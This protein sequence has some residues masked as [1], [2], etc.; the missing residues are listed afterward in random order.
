MRGFTLVELLVT[1]TLLALLLG[2]GFHWQK[3]ALP[4]HRV[5]SASNQV[6]G[7]IQY[8]RAEALTRGPIYL[9][10]GNSHCDRFQV[11]SSLLLAQARD[12]VAA[13]T[14]DDVFH[15]LDLPEG[16]TLTWR[17][18]RGSALRYER[19]GNLYYQNGSF[20][21]CNQGQ[22]RRVIMS[23]MGTARIEPISGGDCL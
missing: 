15:R 22:G 9:C 21:I 10:D 6:L 23:V 3:E 4:R 17:R 11:T 20:L 12:G 19:R 18:F 1:M 2:A 7:L 8:A 5:I 14:N 16:T 13:I